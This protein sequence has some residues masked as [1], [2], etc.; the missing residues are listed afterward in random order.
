MSVTQIV[1]LA[2][3]PFP[4]ARTDARQR[5]SVVTI[6]LPKGGGWGAR[7]ATTRSRQ[8]ARSTTCVFPARLRVIEPRPGSGRQAKAAASA[9]VATTP[10]LSQPHG[11]PSVDRRTIGYVATTGD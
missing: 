9:A 3:R 4:D 5:P 1:C 6:G 8:V 7:R 10:R 2:L 11:S